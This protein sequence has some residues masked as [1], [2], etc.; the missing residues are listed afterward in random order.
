MSDNEISDIEVGETEEEE[1]IVAEKVSRPEDFTLQ[2]QYKHLT[3]SQL[4]SLSF[5]KKL[6]YLS[7]ICEKAILSSEA[8]GRKFQEKSNTIMNN[9]FEV[10][11]TQLT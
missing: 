10:Y 9:V 3:D 7:D 8:K 11:L 2:N 1:K 4:Q 5:I 6:Q